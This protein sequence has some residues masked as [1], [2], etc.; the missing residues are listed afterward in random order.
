MI[1]RYG[2]HLCACAGRVFVEMQQGP[3]FFD[4][5]AQ[6]TRPPDKGKFVNVGFFKCTLAICV[7]IWLHEADILVITDRFRGEIGSS[8]GFFDIHRRTFRPAE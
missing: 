6:S 2:F 7:A 5:K 8:R 1:P 3:T 4:G